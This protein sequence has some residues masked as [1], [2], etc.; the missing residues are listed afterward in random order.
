MK[1]DQERYKQWLD[2][3]KNLCSRQE[4]CTWDVQK[5]MSEW[6]VP[7][8]FNDR[9]IEELKNEK[10]I[11]E[12]RFARSFVRDRFHS[13]HWGR[14]KIAQA[15]RIKKI[16]DDK[17][18]RALEELPDKEY[19]KLLLELMKRKKRNIKARNRFELMGKLQKYAY[20]KGFEPELIQ[21]IMNDVVK[22]PDQ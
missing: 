21:E 5:K 10:Y 16:P 2:R 12:T 22:N 15:L 1:S 7:D 14:I 9:I 4:K 8:H 11:D 17:I 6:S 20:G 19:R 3:A 18:T 13:N